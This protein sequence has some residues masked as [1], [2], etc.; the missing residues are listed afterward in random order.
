VSHIVWEMSGNFRVSEERSPW[1]KRMI[2]FSVMC[3]S[4][5]VW[6][7]AGHTSVN[8][9]QTTCAVQFSEP[10]VHRAALC[11]I[12]TLLRSRLPVRIFSLALYFWPAVSLNPSFIFL[13]S[14]NFCICLSVCCCILRFVI[15]TCVLP[16]WRINVHHIKV[17]LE[18]VVMS[19]YCKPH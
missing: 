11:W 15:R 10:R 16:V 17:S 18:H 12:S 19:Y 3:D 9:Q 13:F 6:C 7:Y 1:M 4:A 2:I 14:L 5:Q 8:T